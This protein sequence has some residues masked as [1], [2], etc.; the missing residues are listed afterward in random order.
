[1]EIKILKLLL[2]QLIILNIKDFMTKHYLKNDTMKESDLQRNY[3]NP[4]HPKDLKIYSYKR[5]VGIDDGFQGGTHWVSSIVKDYKY[6]TPI[7]A[8]VNLIIF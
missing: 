1:M 4:I 5:F 6:F 2:F 3:K 7:V 8:V